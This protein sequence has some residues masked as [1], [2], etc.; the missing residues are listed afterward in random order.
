MNPIP[1]RQLGAARLTVGAVGYGA[2]SFAG[3]YG[4]ELADSDRVAREIVDR[5]LELGV[6]LIDTADIYGDSELNIGHAVRGRRDQVVLSTKF[7]IVTAPFG[8]QEA[9]IDGSPHYV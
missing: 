4:Q 3:P 1:T 9:K 6:T 2:M 8:G 5:A 7:G